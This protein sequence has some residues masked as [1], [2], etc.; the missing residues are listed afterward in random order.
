MDIRLTKD[1]R[2]FADLASAFTASD[3][4]STNVIGVWVAGVIDGTHPQ[5][6]HDVWITILD[7]DR[8]VGVAMH[9]PPFPPFLSRMPATAASELA[10]Y[11]HAAGHRV[12]GV[13]G[14]VTT[15]TAFADTWTAGTCCRSSVQVSMRS[16]QLGTLSVPIG[17]SGG[18]RTGGTDDTY[19]VREWFVSF[20]DEA[21][22][23]EPGEHMTLAADQRLVAGQITL[24]IDEGRAVSMAGHSVPANGVARIGPVYTPPG[25]RRNGY[26][27]A[28]TAA[29][30]LAALDEGADHVV[31]YT[32]LAN[33][34][35]NSIYQNISYVADHDAQRLRFER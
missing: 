8:V 6:D 10:E 35:S 34:T 19:V 24:W 5:G 2:E 12:H 9:T 32:D 14:E 3:P 15:T 28:V 23:H 26:G 1:P 18:A 16:Y 31:L 17:V 29:A 27:A 25:H 33:P 30:S 22:P 7:Q 13:N 4:L 20:H 21:T 11:L